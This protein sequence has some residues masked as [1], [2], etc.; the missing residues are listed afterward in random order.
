M[1]NLSKE[2]NQNRCLFYPKGNK[3]DVKQLFEFN[4]YSKLL[5][6]SYPNILQRYFKI[7]KEKEG[8]R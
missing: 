2:E 1:V 8:E 4:H 5:S 7:N 3:T 6:K